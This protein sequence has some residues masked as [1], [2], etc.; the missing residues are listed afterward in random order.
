M[1]NKQEGVEES[2]NKT[3]LWFFVSISFV[4]IAL[5]LAIMAYFVVNN[6]QNKSIIPFINKD[7]TTDKDKEINKN[8]VRRK[9]DGVYVEIGKEKIQPIAIMIDNH[10]DARP[11]SGLSQANLV[12]EAEAEGG[13][14]R[15]LAFFSTD[16]EIK[17]IGPVRSARPYYIDWAREFNALYA[18]VGGSPEAL[19]KMKKENILHI[20]EF[21]NETY[22]WRDQERLGPHNVYTSTNKMYE[23]LDNNE[24]KKVDFFSWKYKDDLE[25][26]KRPDH[27]QITIEYDMP[28]YEVT[29]EYKKGDNNY[30][31]FNNQEK[32]VDTNGE[33]IQTKNVIVQYIEAEEIDEEL[34]LEMKHIGEGE[35][36]ICLDGKCAEGIW[37]KNNASAKTRYYYKTGDQENIVTKEAILNTRTTWVEVVRPEYKVEYK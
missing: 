32:L 18:H 14:T 34:R 6:Y 19:V 26:E 22:F 33:Q 2:R 17:K 5:I 3:R 36:L 7:K 10:L 23:Y 15:F 4:I 24:I 37:K 16:E 30:I 12:I 13:I 35:A 1:E 25:R 20:N 29:W 9:I 28:G 8:L 21:F 11:P 31:R 27:G